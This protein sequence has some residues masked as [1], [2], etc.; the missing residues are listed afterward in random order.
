MK[1]LLAIGMMLAIL[2]VAYAGEVTADKLK[3]CESA[4]REKNKADKAA[5]PV[6]FK[7]DRERGFRQAFIAE[8]LSK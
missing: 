2:S 3:S 1:M 5:A 7:P 4:Y 8:C 6:G